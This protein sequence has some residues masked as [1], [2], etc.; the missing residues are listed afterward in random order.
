MNL[1]R[2]YYLDTSII[3]KLLIKEKG[4]DILINHMKKEYTSS[5]FYALSFCF[6]E[7]LGVLKSKYLRN[8]I[9]QETYFAC[10]E[11][12]SAFISKDGD[13]ELMDVDIS[14]SSVF[15]EVEKVAKRNKLDI[16]D[17]YQI[18]TIQRDSSSRI[19]LKTEPIIVTADSELARAAC[20]EGLR[21]WNCLIEQE[22][23]V[24]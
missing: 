15:D 9:D 7:A 6:A 14:D 18:V 3:V 13:I 8:E 10:A 16:V 20:K 12:L 1:H 2:V 4:T 24:L 17:A 19:E 11:V 5:T 23:N 22:P 21:V